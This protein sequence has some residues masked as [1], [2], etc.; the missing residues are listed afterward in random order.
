MVTLLSMV[1]AMATI[2]HNQ[3]APKIVWKLS[4][5]SNLTLMLSFMQLH[6]AQV[7]TAPFDGNYSCIVHYEDKAS[8]YH[9]QIELLGSMTCN[10]ICVV[11]L[12]CWSLELRKLQ[13]RYI[14]FIHSF[15]LFIHGTNISQRL[16]F[17]K[18]KGIIYMYRLNHLCM[19]VCMY[20]YVCLYVCIIM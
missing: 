6:W 5:K 20:M 9:V 15:I 11:L 10:N 3:S 18:Y 2:H 12:S 1:T 13:Q 14:L 7:S 4:L 8:L 16:F 19:Y 17:S